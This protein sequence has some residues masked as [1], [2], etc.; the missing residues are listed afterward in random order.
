M[1]VRPQ[2]GR[3]VVITDTHIQWRFSHETL[4]ALACEGGADVIQLRDKVL[5]NDE[6]ARVGERVLAICRAHD[7]QLIINDRVH[8]AKTVG[9]HGVHVG[10]GDMRVQEARV[11]VGSLAVIGTSAGNADEAQQAHRAGADYV[12]VG[13]VFA[14]S[15]KQKTGAP[16]G[17]ETLADAC[18]NTSRPVI[19]VGG[20]TVENAADV[21]RAGAHGI[22]VIS[23]VC[24][25][26]DPR[27]ATAR[28]KEI[29]E[30]NA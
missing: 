23:A 13:H 9:A 18:R 8:V 21:M 14:T 28:L 30:A 27:A 20:I 17:L 6:F 12:G 26:K 24:V 11:V 10:R 4:A 22:A 7:A 15:S 3:L 2:I 29:V 5:P 16:I 19:A 1:T 25:A